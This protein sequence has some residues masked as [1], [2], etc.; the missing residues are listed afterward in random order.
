MGPLWS[1]Q[2]TVP[3]CTVSDLLSIDVL[4][5]PSGALVGAE[6]VLIMNYCT[7]II[8]IPSDVVLIDDIIVSLE[9]LPDIAVT[10]TT[11]FVPGA[12]VA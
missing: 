6:K 3:H 9:K 12:I 7:N 11:Q 2:G 4:E 1:G 10:S 5:S 8:A